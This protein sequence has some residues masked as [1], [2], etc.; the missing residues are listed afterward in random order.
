MTK[1]LWLKKQINYH[2]HMGTRKVYKANDKVLQ[3]RWKAFDTFG[4]ARYKYISPSALHRTTV[5]MYINFEIMFCSPQIS[6][7]HHW[8]SL[9]G[10]EVNP[11]GSKASSTL[12]GHMT[13][14]QHHVNSLWKAYLHYHKSNETWSTYSQS[15]ERCGVGL[16]YTCKLAGA[17]SFFFLVGKNVAP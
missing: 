16:S 8:T 9:F 17:F 15:D 6:H 12:S 14:H 4:G 5:S 11:G 1:H 10:T 3:N 2:L 7:L 13:D